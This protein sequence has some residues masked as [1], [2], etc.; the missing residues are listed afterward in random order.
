MQ[1]TLVDHALA[2]LGPLEL[3]DEVTKNIYQ[4]F[5]VIPVGHLLFWSRIR[6]FHDLLPYVK[7]LAIAMSDLGHVVD[8]T[9]DVK[10]TVQRTFHSTPIRYIP[11]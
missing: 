11:S 9:F 10:L 4:K 6:M 1:A 5:S 8:Y 7:S 3:G 2:A